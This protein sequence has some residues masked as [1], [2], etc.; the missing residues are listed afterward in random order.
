MSAFY[1]KDIDS[2]RQEVNGSL[3][4]LSNQQVKI[5]QEKYGLNELVEEKRR[6]HFRFFWSNIRIF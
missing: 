5:N 6:Q 1:N 4:P 2:V 3:E